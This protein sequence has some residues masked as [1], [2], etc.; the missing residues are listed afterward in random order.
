MAKTVTYLLS[1]VAGVLL[2]V[3][4]AI[5]SIQRVA[6]MAADPDPIATPPPV[7]ES[8][9]NGPAAFGGVDAPET[10]TGRVL[11]SVTLEAGSV[12]AVVNGRASQRLDGDAV[13]DLTPFTR[14][15]RNSIL[16]RWDGT[17]C[18]D[19]RV[20]RVGEDGSTLEAGRA[21]L[22]RAG[23]LRPGARRMDFYL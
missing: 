7:A 11:L 18:A 8:P 23:T 12:E 5:P 1:A 19:L 20:T 6:Q 10:T 17:A 22:S 14:P 3:S 21:F 15:G 2:A 13:Y 9:P 4:L 16:L